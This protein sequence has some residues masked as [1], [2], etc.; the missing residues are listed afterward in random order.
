MLSLRFLS[1]GAR[2]P[3]RKEKEAAVASGVG[4]REALWAGSQSPWTS[5]LLERNL[6][7]RP[8]EGGSGHCEPGPPATSTAHHQQRGLG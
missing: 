4:R 1:P 6:R 5:R 7:M 2:G 8:R 3:W